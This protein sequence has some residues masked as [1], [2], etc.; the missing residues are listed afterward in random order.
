VIIIE[1]A[2]TPE[3]EVAPTATPAATS[4]PEATAPPVATATPSIVTSAPTAPAAAPESGIEPGISVTT[5]DSEANLRGGP[6]LDAEIVST[7]PP[8]SELAVTGPAVIGDDFVWW[9][10]IVVATGEEGFV[11]EEL[12]TPLGE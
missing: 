12:L 7:V 4:T 8:G 2:V 3:G 10:V 9:P 11:A 6:S 1:G 5:A